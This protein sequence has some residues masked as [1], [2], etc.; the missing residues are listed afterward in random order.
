MMSGY[1]IE[2]YIHCFREAIT[3][4]RKQLRN[5]NT[6]QSG[7]MTDIFTQ[8]EVTVRS[9]LLECSHHHPKSPGILSGLLVTLDLQSHH[10]FSLN[11]NSKNNQCSYRPSSKAAL[12]LK[13]DIISYTD[14]LL[15]YLQKYSSH[16]TQFGSHKKRRIAF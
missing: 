7:P 9:N 4:K 1:N 2:H 15:L 6:V 3:N 14:T 13:V 10:P 11:T 12:N 8:S 16:K 5:D